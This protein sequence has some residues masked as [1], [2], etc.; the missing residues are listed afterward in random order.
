MNRAIFF[1][2]PEHLSIQSRNEDQNIFL[3]FLYLLLCLK[4]ASL[5]KPEIALFANASCKPRSAGI[6]GITEGVVPSHQPPFSLINS[7]N[8]QHDKQVNKERIAEEWPSDL[9]NFYL[10]D[11]PH[12]QKRKRDGLPTLVTLPFLFSS[13]P[14]EACLH[15][16]QPASFRSGWGG[17]KRR[18]E[19]DKQRSTVTAMLE[20]RQ[21]T[22]GVWLEGYRR[23]ASVWLRRFIIKKRD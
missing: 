18:G 1:S 14:V 15:P 19:E 13:V 8:G 9:Y 10:C 11:R 3:S 20:S 22:G 12:L 16:R 4:L 5:L 21:Q 17:K 23:R 6:G 7:L 2:A